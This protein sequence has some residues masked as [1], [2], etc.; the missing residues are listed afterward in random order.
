[1]R[2]RLSLVFVAVFGLAGCAF[3]DRDVTLK[4]PPAPASGSAQAA[5]KAKPVPKGG[6]PVVV[7]TF[8]DSRPEKQI[9][10]FVQNG[11]GMKTADVKTSSNVAEW[12][13]R[14][15]A[16]ELRR[17]GYSVT[18]AESPPPGARAL[19]VTGTVEKALTKAYFSYDAEI[20]LT[21]AIVRGKKKVAGRRYSGRGSAGTNIAGTADRFGRSLSLALQDALQGLIADLN[22]V[23]R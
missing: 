2:F 20:V 15:T 11:Y 3:G 10:G 22:A 12:V 1:M 9:I 7:G 18:L 8:T 21:A 14:A 17:R 13:R 5:M 16:F 23:A 19:L 4:Y 6:L